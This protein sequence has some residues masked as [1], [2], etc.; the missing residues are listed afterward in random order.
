MPGGDDIDDLVTTSSEMDIIDEM[1]TYYPEPERF[2]QPNC[3][4]IDL[5]FD[6]SLLNI[7][8]SKYNASE[9]KPF[10]NTSLVS[11]IFL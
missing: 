7:G 4:G 10:L 6:Y 3:K 11:C 5:F 2:D 1:V 8:L 9:L